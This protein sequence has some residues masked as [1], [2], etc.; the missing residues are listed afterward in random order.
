[1]KGWRRL[2]GIFGRGLAMG[3]A[4]VIPG[5][6]GGTIAF[7]TGIYDRLLG[8][9]ASWS[10]QS[11]RQL[12]QEGPGAV[13]RSHDLAFLCT[14]GAGMVV[15]YLATARVIGHLLE[16]YAPALWAFFLGLIAASI[17]QLLRETPLRFA[18]T[19]GV[20]GAALGVAVATLAAASANPGLPQFFLG[21]AVAVT[22]WILPGISGSLVLLLLGLYEP[23]VAAV[24]GFQFDILAATGAGMAIGLLAFAKA[25]SFLL[26]RHRAQVI[27]A[28]T[29]LMA[30]SMARLWPWRVD[31]AWLGP[32][33][34]RA[35][36][37]AE[38]LLLGVVLTALAGVGCALL[39]ARSGQ[40]A[41][42]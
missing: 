3:V 23:F 1:M 32:S 35:V 22:A 33:A 13:W 31:D 40:A 4:E 24:N 6:S 26:R 28:L 14:L 11:V 37:G 25:V 30:G 10:P 42:A 16:H 7:I 5:V 39:L 27:A 20:L 2:S 29:G 17:L 38:P 34:Y 21:G 15:S 19:F 8:A 12:F 36:T 41:S 9:L 18:A